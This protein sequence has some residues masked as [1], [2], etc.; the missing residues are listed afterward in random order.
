MSQD[1]SEILDKKQL[2]DLLGVSERTIERWVAEGRI[3]YIRLPKRGAWAEV[4]FMKSNI[5]KWLIRKEVKPN[6]SDAESKVR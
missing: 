4:R 3:P 5:I 6:T 2:S 1:A